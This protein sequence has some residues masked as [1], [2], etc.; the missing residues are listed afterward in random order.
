MTVPGHDSEPFVI[1]NPVVKEA[2]AELIQQT[3]FFVLQLFL[4]SA[5]AEGW[6]DASGHACKRFA[7]SPII[8]YI[9]TFQLGVIPGVEDFPLHFHFPSEALKSKLLLALQLFFS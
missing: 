6:H 4:P 5:I 1:R 3:P 2:G 8:Y 7:S 9:Y